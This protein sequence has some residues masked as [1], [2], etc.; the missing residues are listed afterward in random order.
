MLFIAQP[1]I[2]SF[3][4][5]PSIKAQKL[6]EIRLIDL[7]SMGLFAKKQKDSTPPIEKKDLIYCDKIFTE[8]PKNYGKPKPLSKITEEQFEKYT[9]VLTHF[10]D[11][12]LQLPVNTSTHDEKRPLNAEE[13]RWLTRECLLRY[14]RAT[15]WDV[16]KA[17][18]GLTAT[19]T[20]RREVGLSSGGVNAKPLTQDVT[21][22]ENETGKQIVLGFDINR[23]PLFY[24]KNGRQNTEPSFRQV[25]HLIFMMESAVTI[26]PQGVET[27]TVLIDF[28]N[29]K[30]P[31]INSDKMPP[32]SISKLCMN[33]MQNHYPERLGKCVLVNIPWFAWAFLKMMHP[34]L[35]PRTREKAIFDEPFENHIEPSQL[36]AIYNGKLDFKYKHDV[37]WPDFCNKVDEIKTT[38]FNRFLKFGG[39]VGLSEFDLKGK[40]DDITYPVDFKNV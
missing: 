2:R 18:E 33:V 16:N 31:G 20:W 7:L 8:P 37:Y 9:A 38:E 13:K 12:S 21:S 4:L 3:Q 11:K 36:E 14:L 26:A 32:L 22:V 25:Q 6:G 1:Y 5:K 34:F 10:Q 17:I 27:I 23:R 39:V 24:L 35:D 19:L 40:H 29:Y 28:K 15:K 30:E